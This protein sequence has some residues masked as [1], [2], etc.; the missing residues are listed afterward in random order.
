MEILLLSAQ[1]RGLLK[2]AAGRFKTV[3]YRHNL[4]GQANFP[5]DFSTDHDENFGRYQL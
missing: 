1:I 2:D 3:I 5:T 4:S